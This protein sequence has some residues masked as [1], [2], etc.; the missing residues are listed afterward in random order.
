MLHVLPHFTADYHIYPEV[1]TEEWLLFLHSLK[2]Y[3]LTRNDIDLMP[4]LIISFSHSLRCINRLSAGSGKWDQNHPS[5]Q[6]KKDKVRRVATVNNTRASQQELE[7]WHSLYLP[8]IKAELY[9][10]IQSASCS[11]CSLMWQERKWGKKRKYNV[12]IESF[13][14]LVTILLT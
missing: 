4:L 7:V 1:L 14:S 10:G 8:F 13:I 6:G 5:E 9:W 11:L 3:F 2:G 12:M